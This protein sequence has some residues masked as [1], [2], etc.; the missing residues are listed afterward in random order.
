VQE[1]AAELALGLLSGPERADALLHMDSCAACRT[2]VEELADVADGMLLLAPQAEP[3]AGFETGVVA[4]LDGREPRRAPR[5]RALA[6]AAAIA[7]VLGAVGGALVARDRAGS[8]LDHEYV[9]ALEQLDGRAL[10]AARL[11]DAAGRQVGQLFLYEG[12]TSW[13]FVTVDDPRSRSD[14]ELAVELRFEDGRRVLVPGLRLTA[15]RGSLGTT[16]TLRLRDL[17][18]VR[19]IDQAGRARYRVERPR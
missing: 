10:A 7:F 13:L 5:R 12:K 6:I 18:G 2:T 19:V 3:P 14:G 1:A 15:G 11:R 9:A 17:E 8:R 16:V 4:R